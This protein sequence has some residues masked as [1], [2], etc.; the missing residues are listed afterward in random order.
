MSSQTDSKNKRVVLLEFPDEAESYLEHCRE[1]GEPPTESHVISLDPKTQV[2]L[3]RWGVACSSSMPYFDSEAHARA[4]RKSEELFRWLE[5]RFEIEDALGI[6]GAY[7]NALL[8]YS[9]FFIHHM[10]WLAELLAE[11]HAQHPG[12]TLA[13]PDGNPDGSQNPLIQDDERYLAA[14][15]ERYCHDHEIPFQPIK[16]LASGS[17]IKGNSNGQSFL[18]P[19]GFR[20]GGWLYRTAL[21]RMGNHRPFMA[22]TH[23]YRGDFLSQ[24]V[25]EAHPEI[26]WVIRGEKGGSLSKG[27]MLRRGLQLMT[28]GIGKGNGRQYMGEFWLRVLQESMKEDPDF[29]GRAAKEVDNLAEEVKAEKGLFSHRDVF[30]GDHFAAKLRTGIG[31]AIRYLQREI[32]A[33]DEVLDLVKPRMVVTPFGRRS[34]HAL[35]ELTQRKGIP[36]LLI[37]HGSF[38]PMKTDLEEIGWRFH[39]HGLFHGTYSH[40]ALQTPLAEA[41]AQQV[42]ARTEFLRTGPLLWGIKMGREPAAGLPGL[43]A[44][45]APF[46]TDCRIV[47]HAGTPSRA[48]PCTS[49]YTRPPTSTS[50]PCV[51]WS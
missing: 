51:T 35:G 47:V 13:C 7:S 41:F 2:W 12:A 10:L 18:R 8:W 28:A 40:S 36:G 26:P 30:F 27:D 31:S 34:L 23:G 49:T 15:A 43:K 3:D 39:S 50:P 9:R 17:G 45:L 16:T 11:V 19:L 14:L 6:S 32:A 5:T 48:G 4:L 1:N 33:L 20:V 38:T 25:R 37:S 21:R 24:E 42:P 44:K 22:I 46:H 29:S